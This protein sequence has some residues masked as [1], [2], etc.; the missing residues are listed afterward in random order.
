ML[1]T[2][3]SIVVVSVLPGTVSRALVEVAFVCGVAAAATS[4][5]RES[6]R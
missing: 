4:L 3:L 1:R 5:R 6:L 2:I